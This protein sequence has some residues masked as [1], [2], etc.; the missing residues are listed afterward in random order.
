MEHPD[1]YRIRLASEE[2]EEYLYLKRLHQ[3]RFI[4]A[5][6]RKTACFTPT[7]RMLE[8]MAG[9]VAKDLTGNPTLITDEYLRGI[10]EPG[11]T[12]T[13]EATSPYFYIPPLEVRLKPNIGWSER[14]TLKLKLPEV[15]CAGIFSDRHCGRTVV[16]AVWYQ[17]EFALPI[18]ESVIEQLRGIDFD[19]YC[20][21][22]YVPEGGN[23][24][25]GLG[26]Y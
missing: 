15:V 20:Y 11:V 10:L 2:E 7:P 14:V 26:S 17:D 13:G 24:L 3:E 6:E 5:L 23:W 25:E 19:R 22:D 4:C 9:R 18:D 8:F 1:I 12:G 21:D 16:L